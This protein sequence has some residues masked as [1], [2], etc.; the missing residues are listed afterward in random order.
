MSVS[1]FLQ[2]VALTTAT[3]LPLTVLTLSS[4][5]SAPADLELSLVEL[6]VLVS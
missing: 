4:A 2:T 1:V 3:Q 5:S 6:N